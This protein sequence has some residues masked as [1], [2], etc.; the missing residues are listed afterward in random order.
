MSSEVSKLPPQVQERLLRLQSIENDLQAVRTQKKQL[1][2]A[3]S[4]VG[5]ALDELEK[6]SEDAV[7]YK[8]IGS[9]LVKSEKKK[10]FNDLTEK[11]ELYT[12]R[13]SV[14]DRQEK[15]LDSQSRDLQ[16]KLQ[17]DLRPVSPSP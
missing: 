3:L 10:V 6:L 17:R 15:R 13:I 9:L 4:E 16:S 8:S 11:R 1:E 7:I 2:L 14:L 5:Q 12:T